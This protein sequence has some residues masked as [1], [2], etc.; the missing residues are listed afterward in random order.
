MAGFTVKGQWQNADGLPVKFPQAYTD[1]AQRINKPVA[2]AAD[3]V[4]VREIVIPFDL[5]KLAATNT[6]YTTDLTNSGATTG[7]AEHDAHI[8]A[9]S[10]V[11]SAEMY[12]TTAG[13]GGTSLTVGSY[14]VDGTAITANGF[15]T[16]TEAVVANMA[17]GN[18]IVGAGAHVTVTAGV[19]A[20]IG[21][22]NVWP[23]ITVTGTFTAGAGYI[24]IRYVD[25]AS[26]PELFSLNA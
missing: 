20:T 6:S 19:R 3:Q 21:N 4:A 5:S 11:L 15:I 9:N 24:V 2:L 12:F 17:K 25:L 1:L 18:G 14:K 8:P 23:A 22:S 16:A 7:F 26:N 10:T 13:A